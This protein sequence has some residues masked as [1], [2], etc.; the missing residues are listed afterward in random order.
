MGTIN[1]ELVNASH[2]YAVEGDEFNEYDSYNEI[3]YIRDSFPYEDGWEPDESYH[4]NREWRNAR[5]IASKHVELTGCETVLKLSIFANPGY[6][7]G[8]T[9]D[10]DIESDGMMI[11]YCLTDF[12]REHASRDMADTLAENDELTPAQRKEI[13]STIAKLREEAEAICKELAVAI[14]DRPGWVMTKIA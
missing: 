2:V 9:L 8:V 5:R 7:E 12:C 6:Y 14:Y 4:S 1:Y 10:Y 11:D 13:A 3:D